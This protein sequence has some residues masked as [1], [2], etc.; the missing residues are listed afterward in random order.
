MS[1]NAILQLLQ[2]IA[3]VDAV[4]VEFQLPEYYKVIEHACRTPNTNI[5]NS[6]TLPI[7]HL[8]SPC[9]PLSLT[10]SS[11]S[12]SSSAFPIH[13]FICIA[14]QL[15][16]VPF[17]TAQDP[18]PHVSLCW[19]SGDWRSVIQRRIKPITA[20]GPTTVVEAAATATEETSV[21]ATN[22]SSN[23]TPTAAATAAA[24][25]SS[26]NPAIVEGSESCCQ[27]RGLLAALPGTLSTTDVTVYV[28]EVCVKIGNKLFRL[29]LRRAP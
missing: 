16:L 20:T 21:P 11:L 27:L 25:E 22:C 2:L 9:V 3:A 29:P 12:T 7:N 15:V 19:A 4:M 10:H 23:A 17:F 5:N 24:T 6:I 8:E 13:T 14:S 26:P 28:S 18:V 1:G